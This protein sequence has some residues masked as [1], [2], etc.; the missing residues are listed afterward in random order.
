MSF[1]T[2]RRPI[3]GLLILSAVGCFGSSA[4]RL[5]P[6]EDYYIAQEIW[7]NERAMLDDFERSMGPNPSEKDLALHATLKERFD[8]AAAHVKAVRARLPKE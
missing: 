6:W 1:R 2:L 5:D 3:V 7:K 8:K 4:S